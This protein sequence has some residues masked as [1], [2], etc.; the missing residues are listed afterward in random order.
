MAVPNISAEELSLIK[1]WLLLMFIHKVFERD[2]RILKTSGVLKNPEIY[3]DMIIGG[4]QRAQV[5]MTEVQ[6]ELT[7]RR[8]KIYEV[9]QSDQGT[10]ARYTCRGYRGEMHI[11]WSTFRNEMPGR[12]RAYLGIQQVMPDHSLSSH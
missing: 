6:N 12:M 9:K 11:L 5:V 3:S 2:S 1:S 10:Q 4:A 7:K 8:I